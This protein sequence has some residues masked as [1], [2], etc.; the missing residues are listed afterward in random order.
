MKVHAILLA[1][2][3]FLSSTIQG[4]K[5]LVMNDLHLNLTYDYK[6]TYGACF[7]LAK[8]GRDSSHELIKKVMEKASAQAKEEKPDAILLLGD[9]VEHD[10]DVNETSGMTY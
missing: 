5:I 1:M 3:S 2:V 9:F 7:D 8:F 10:I 6:C 4:Y